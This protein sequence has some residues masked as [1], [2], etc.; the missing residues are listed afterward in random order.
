MNGRKNASY[1]GFLKAIAEQNIPSFDDKQE[2]FIKYI[3]EMLPIVRPYEY[4]I[5][6][7][8]L[9]N[10]GI[11]VLTEIESYV[12][13]N[14]TGYN[15]DNF[16]HALKY[17]TATEYFSLEDDYL[18][19]NVKLGVEMDAY[20]RD[21][22]E[23]GLGKYDIDFSDHDQKQLF[24]LWKPYRK[25]QVQLLLL[26][27]PNDIM[28]GT[29][30]YDDT[31]YVYVTVIKDKSLKEELKYADGYIDENTFQWE[32]V[33]K[34]SDNELNQLKKSKC[35]HIFVRK[36]DNEDGI[37][38]PF[39]YIGHGHMEYVENSRKENGAHLFRIP[40]SEPAPEDMFFDFK[41]PN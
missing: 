4:L 6:Q 27:N 32:T 30:I 34:V 40:M 37:Q 20:L 23:Y 13:K 1:Y 39:T 38:L 18:L 41:L 11:A 9:D 33:A 5:V 36:V 26:N 8:L 29:K 17:M 28:K 16:K 21:L 19:L 24:H 10:A 15:Q 31:V 2:G 35:V 7:K 25:D 14:A 12:M 22:L 3:S